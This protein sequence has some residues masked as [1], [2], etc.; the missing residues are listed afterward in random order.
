MA[1]GSVYHV[2]CVSNV[3]CAT[4]Y[5]IMFQ[6]LRLTSRQITYG[7]SVPI[8]I[9]SYMYFEILT[10]IQTVMMND[11]TLS[12]WTILLVNEPLLLFSL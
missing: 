11:R 12:R 2:S 1:K 8:K 10:G 6:Q 7:I 4:L 9:D 5:V 3:G